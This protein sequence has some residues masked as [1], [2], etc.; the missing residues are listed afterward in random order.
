MPVTSVG[1]TFSRF[2]CGQ[3]DSST[4][5]AYSTIASQ[6]STETSD[7]SQ[8]VSTVTKDAS[9]NYI[10]ETETKTVSLPETTMSSTSTSSRSP[11]ASATTIPAPTSSI[12]DT[13]VMSAE[14]PAGES[15]TAAIAG[16]VVGGVGGALAV[17]GIIGYLV[18]RKKKQRKEQVPE[19]GS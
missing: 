17:A 12:V 19:I 10:T 11:T 16:G 6:R 7:E 14:R 9:D 13:S 15:H 18:Y 4:I 3:T 1:G 5:S 8:R 2:F